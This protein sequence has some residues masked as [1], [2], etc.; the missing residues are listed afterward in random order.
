MLGLTQATIIA[1]IGNDSLF[2][3]EELCRY[4]GITNEQRKIID[5]YSLIH[6]MNLIKIRRNNNVIHSV[7]RLEKSIKDWVTDLSR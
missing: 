5:F 2:Y 3:V 4:W 7:Q 6:S 1:D